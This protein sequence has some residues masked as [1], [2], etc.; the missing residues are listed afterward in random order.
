MLKA[1]QDLG[2]ASA[3]RV[4]FPFHCWLL[5]KQALPGGFIPGFKAGLSGFLFSGFIPVPLLDEKYTPPE[6]RKRH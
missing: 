1:A 3:S 2:E 6:N 4:Y 5:L